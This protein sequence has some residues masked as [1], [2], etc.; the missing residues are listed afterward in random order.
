MNIGALPQLLVAL[1][2]GQGAETLQAAKD[3]AAAAAFRSG[4]QLEGR[5]LA[6][7]P[8]GRN[9]VRVGGQ[10]LDM[11]LP[12][13]AAPGDVLRLT[14]LHAAPRPTFVLNQP[15]VAGAASVRLSGAAQQVSALVRYV[16]VTATPV[17]GIGASAAV[18][19]AA[20]ALP[21]VSTPIVP[22]P[23]VL[24][25]PVPTHA[26]A[27]TNITGP[28]LPAL[29]VAGEAVEGMRAALASNTSLTAQGAIAEKA[30]HSHLLPSLLRDTVKQS[31]LFYESHLG[32]WVKGELPMEAIQ[33]E[34]QA[35]LRQA[36]G[37]LLDLPDLEGMPAEAA[38]LASRQLTMLEGG[39]FV[40]LGQAWPGQTLRWTVEERDGGEVGAEEGPRWRSQL[41]L[42]LPR[43]GEVVADLEIGAQGLGVRLAARQ[44]ATVAEM[45]SALQELEGRLRELDLGLSTLRAEPLPE[46]EGGGR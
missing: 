3:P 36:P 14:F 41:H 42:H 7:L 10:A 11:A 27:L 31:G 13:Q 18:A 15:A 1:L 25:A 21:G 4:Q 24:L 6:A 37:P 5:V 12:K 39:P 43:L 22:N 45:R 30:A 29:A 28:A 44:T 32:R 9:L 17:G 34:P 20:A 16:P 33:R 26:G 38:R 46:D 40:W 35:G 2:R 8:D 19:G 23:A